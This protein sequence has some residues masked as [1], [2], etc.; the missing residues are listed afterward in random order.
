MD[1]RGLLRGGFENRFV[2]ELTKSGATAFPTYEFLSLP[3]IERDK[4]AA[5]EQLR[6]KGAEGVVVMRLIDV[7]STYR[8]SRPGPE[9][10]S[11]YVTGFEPGTWYDY[12]SVAY[13][14]MSPT[15]GNLKLKVYLETSLFELKT[16]KRVWSGMSQT[17]VTE[18]MDRMAEMDP[19]VEK[20][21]AAMRQDGVIP[22]S[23]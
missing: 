9:R 20:F 22:Q 23:P 11:E 16:A 1:D 18:T 14:D 6:A 7:S 10:Y 2:N 5:A 21:V 8:E 19:I 4:P 13:A 3:E 15:F 12:Y 17:V